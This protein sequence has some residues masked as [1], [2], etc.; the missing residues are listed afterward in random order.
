M[1]SP[2]R[3]ELRTLGRIVTTQEVRMNRWDAITHSPAAR[4]AR[5]AWDWGA[6]LLTALSPIFLGAVFYLAAACGR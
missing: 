1:V 3:T 2:I 5:L 6:I 4:H